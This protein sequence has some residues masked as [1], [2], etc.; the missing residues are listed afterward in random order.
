MSAWIPR[1]TLPALVLTAFVFSQH[2][3]DGQQPQTERGTLQHAVPGT[4]FEFEII[5][6]FDAKYLG[7]TPGHIGHAG[8]LGDTRPQVSLGDPIYRDQEVV[9]HVSN[10]FWSHFKGS[11]TVEFHP[12]PLTRIAVG[13]IVAVD[14]NPARAADADE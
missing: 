12:A 9:G 14:L 1:L 10:L 13:D 2:A 11:L 6:S 3:G 7:D 8:G 4:R 5:E